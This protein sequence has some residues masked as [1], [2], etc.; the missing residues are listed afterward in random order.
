MSIRNYRD[1]LRIRQELR[2]ECKREN[3]KNWE[4]SIENTINLSGDT[5]AFWNKI[6]QLKGNN[7]THTNYLEDDEGNKYY[8]DAEKCSYMENIWQNIFRITETEEATFDVNSIIHGLRVTP[9]HNK[10]LTR[11][12]NDCFYTSPVDNEKKDTYVT[13]KTKRLDQP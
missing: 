6:K 11:L 10:D 2:D 7:T 9:Y 8:A 4:N 1:F 12:N 5:K 13:Q 3:S